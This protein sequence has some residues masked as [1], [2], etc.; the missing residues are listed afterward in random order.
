MEKFDAAII[1]AGADGLAAAALLARAGLKTIVVECN[2]RSGGKLETR[3]FHPGFRASAY[4]DEIAPIPPEIFWSLDLA[5]RGALFMPAHDS[6]AL[7]P[8]RSETLERCSGNP[9]AEAERRARALLVRAL[10]D[11]ARP[12]RFW[13]FGPRETAADWP[14]EDW[15]GASLADAV[16]RHAADE[17]VPAHLAARA[18]AGRAAD[19]LLPGTALHLLVPGTGSSGV[20]RGGLGTLGAAL[21]EAAR[22][23]GAQFSFGLEVADIRRAR[24]RVQGITLADGSEIGASAVISTLDLKRTFLSLFSW[25]ALPQKL[26]SR[27]NGFRMAA[28]TARLLVA[29]DSLPE[30]E[31]VSGPL[32]RAHGPIHIA[33]DIAALHDAAAAWRDGAL[34]D[35]LPLTLRFPS[36]IDP[37]LAP[38]GAATLT[39]TI[40]AVPHRLFDGAWTH[41]KRAVLR[42]RALKSIENVFPGLSN[43]VRATE[44]L[45]PP[46]IE[47]ALGLTDGDLAGGEIAPDQM[48]A[49][50]PWLEGPPVPRTPISGLYIAGPSTMAGVLATCASGAA[51]ARAVLADLFRSR[52]LP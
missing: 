45:L 2:A 1:G 23:A 22:E 17:T 5:R 8:G 6:R 49:T 33:P 15:A 48:F 44:L 34:P 41:D 3:E 12:S 20:V 30:V 43:R 40:G 28:G 19:P 52:W 18:L 38:T 46:D 7:W 32:R 29:L 25:T 24:G 37:A 47:E 13:N 36:A 21:E 4:A 14:S 26:A 10:A 50:R 16:A 39:V 27:V 31:G 35:V 11:V 42:D 9:I 51:A